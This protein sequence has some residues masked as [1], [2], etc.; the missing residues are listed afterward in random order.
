M[1]LYIVT[2]KEDNALTYEQTFNQPISSSSLFSFSRIFSSLFLPREKK[3]RPEFS[4]APP[5]LEMR[6][7][8]TFAWNIT[9]DLPPTAQPNFGHFSFRRIRFL[10]FHDRDTKAY[11][12]HMR[13]VHERGGDGVAGSL[14][15]ASAA[16]DLHECRTVDG[17]GCECA[18]LLRVV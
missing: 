9:S 1:L 12:F 13:S 18:L 16:E 15:S 14:G 4:P 2:Y 6:T 11:R 17:G 10:G 3:S 7:L 8:L 5:Q